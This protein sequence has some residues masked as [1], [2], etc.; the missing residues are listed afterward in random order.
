MIECSN[1]HPKITFSEDI[2]HCPICT[3]WSEYG[4]VTIQV[5]ALQKQIA[6]RAKIDEA[7]KMIYETLA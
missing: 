6:K 5:G 4:K 1:G 3:V 2:V 7:V